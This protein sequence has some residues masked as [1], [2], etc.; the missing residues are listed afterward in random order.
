MY[1]AE[2]LFAGSMALVF[3]KT[4]PRILNSTWPLGSQLKAKAHSDA[5]STD[6]SAL[7]LNFKLC[8]WAAA[9]PI[10]SKET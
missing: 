7:Q 4:T 1:A 6:L 2:H 10:Q 5:G 8:R 3:K 9:I